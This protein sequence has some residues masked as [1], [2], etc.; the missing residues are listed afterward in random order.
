MKEALSPGYDDSGAGIGGDEDVQCTEKFSIAAHD[1][2]REKAQEKKKESSANKSKDAKIYL[3]QEVY[4][5]KESFSEECIEVLKGLLT[6]KV[7][8]R[9]ACGPDKVSGLKQAAW[10]KK[11]KIDWKQL[12]MEEMAAPYIPKKEVN[13]KDESELKQFNTKGMKNL[14]PEDQAKWSDWAWTSAEYMQEEHAV[15]YYNDWWAHEKKRARGG[16]GG[17]G[18]GGCCS[19]Q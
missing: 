15:H 18:G 16:G 2:V 19:L 10:F 5:K 12:E 3:T 14:T 6:R 8:S 11:N 1:K 9:L 7:D 4:V 13:A 17:G